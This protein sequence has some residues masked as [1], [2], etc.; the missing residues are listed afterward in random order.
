[1]KII[2]ENLVILT[3]FKKKGK[4]NSFYFPIQCLG[5]DKLLKKIRDFLD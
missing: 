2:D 4:L 1:M 3:Q 5:S